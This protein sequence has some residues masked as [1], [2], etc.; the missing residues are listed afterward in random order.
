MG[1]TNKRKQMIE[2]IFRTA[3]GREIQL[4]EIFDTDA[5]W[6]YKKCASPTEQF[7]NNVIRTLEQVKADVFK[8]IDD[9]P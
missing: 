4:N 9:S 6:A 7:S 1:L 2:N 5:W 8:V 3:I